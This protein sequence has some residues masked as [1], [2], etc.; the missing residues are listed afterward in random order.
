MNKSTR[1]PVN[2]V[3]VLLTFLMIAVIG[4]CSLTAS[5]DHPIQAAQDM[6]GK[7]LQSA[8]ILSAG[9]SHSLALRSDGTL[10]AWGSNT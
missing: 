3:R 9:L 5:S 7:A 10:W 4:L 8:P 6:T 1:I 2:A